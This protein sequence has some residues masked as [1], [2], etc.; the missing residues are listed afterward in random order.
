ME[1]LTKSGALYNVALN[2][3]LHRQRKTCKNKF[4]DPICWEC[5]H[6][7][8]KY[9][10]ADDESV[11][12]MMY[13]AEGQAQMIRHGNTFHRN[14]VLIIIA[15]CVFLGARYHYK[16]NGNSWHKDDSLIKEKQIQDTLHKVAGVLE[17]L[18]EYNCDTATGLFY[19]WFPVKKDVRCIETKLKESKTKHSFN[20]VRVS[21]TWID[22]EPQSFFGRHDTYSMKAI[23]KD[24]YQPDTN[25]V[26]TEEFK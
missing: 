5:D 26:I 25:R 11:N 24:R 19:H 2:C 15:I 1:P 22:V 20:Q 13:E 7:L 21:G 10:N 8:R 4:N 14:L 23:W 9:V 3:A 17:S 6:F 16:V 12:L 18:D